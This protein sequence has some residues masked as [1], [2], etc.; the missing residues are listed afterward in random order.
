MYCA[1]TG[2]MKK[3]CMAGFIC[4]ALAVFSGGCSTTNVYQ[5]QY[6]SRLDEVFVKQG[7]DFSRYHSVIIDDVSVWYPTEHSPSPENVEKA[8]ANLTRAQRL[9]RQTISDAL[10][11]NYPVTDMP[12]KDVLRVKAE[13][14]DLRALQPG[15]EIPREV[16]RLEFETRPGHI[17]MTARLLDS[18]TGE[19][20]A[21]A[22]DLGKKESVGGDGVVDWDA[23]THD[24]D[25]W[26]AV[27]REWMDEVHGER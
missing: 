15:V 25:Y 19:L 20:L 4:M 24:F 13:F 23:I 18:R 14:V 1:E 3:I 8:R 10:S 12:G 6:E 22:A 26:A 21:R 5:Y 11:E 27:F 2:N 16:A 9:F 17:T 7:V